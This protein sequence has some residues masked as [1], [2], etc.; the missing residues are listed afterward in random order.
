MQEEL[1]FF[2]FWEKVTVQGAFKIKFMSPY[3]KKYELFYVLVAS[4]AEA[5]CLL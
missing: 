4:V 2:V 5:V 3:K 1:T